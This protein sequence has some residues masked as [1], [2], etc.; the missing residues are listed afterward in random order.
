M[1]NGDLEGA[2]RA[3]S[4]IRV[5]SYKA[6]LRRLFTEPDERRKRYRRF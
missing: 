5:L 1:P 3:G 4:E 2:V 6:W